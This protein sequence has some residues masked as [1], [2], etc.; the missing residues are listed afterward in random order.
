[1]R[2][3]E[4]TTPIPQHVRQAGN[5]LV[6]VQLVGT[7]LSASWGFSIWQEGFCVQGRCNWT[8]SAMD[9]AAEADRALA[10]LDADTRTE[11]VTKA[12]QRGLVML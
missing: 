5:R 3:Y 12:A 10:K 1:M 11:A 7:G 9:A 6:V 4:E 2:N 8:W